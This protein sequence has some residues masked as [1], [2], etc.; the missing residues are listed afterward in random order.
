VS[1]DNENPKNHDTL[2]S[3]QVFGRRNAG[4]RRLSQT[5]WSQCVSNSVMVMRSMVSAAL[6]HLP[7]LRLIHLADV[8]DAVPLHA[9]V[10]QLTLPFLMPTPLTSPVRRHAAFSSPL[11]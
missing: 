6:P 10:G 7:K 5:S 1:K 8:N 3:S 2:P 4:A 9:E 11:P